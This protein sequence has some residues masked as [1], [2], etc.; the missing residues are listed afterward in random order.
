MV[1]LDEREELERLELAGAT[2]LTDELLVD[3][4]ALREAFVEALRDALV[5]A[6]RE[7][8]VVVL[9]DALV[10]ALREADVAVVLRDAA[11]VA[12]RSVA[13]ADLPV[14][15]DAVTPDVRVAL[16]LAVADAERV[17]L[18]LRFLSHPPPLTLRLGT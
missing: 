13:P 4:V 8:F 17:A 18:R 12:L 9:R 7:A 6:L 16:R 1:L 5:V 3:C 2:F 15:L 14:A 10:V 11:V